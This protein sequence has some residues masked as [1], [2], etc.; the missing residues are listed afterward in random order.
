MDME[1]TS[2]DETCGCEVACLSK[3]RKRWK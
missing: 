2:V 3:E 1:C